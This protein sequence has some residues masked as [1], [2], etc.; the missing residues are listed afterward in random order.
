V[1][2]LYLCGAGNSEGVR[3]AHTINRAED[4]WD[5][6]LLLD[7]DETKRGES[8][9]GVEIVGSLDL[10][11]DPGEGVV[12]IANLVARTTQ[13]RAAVRE[14]LLAFD[15][16]FATLISPNVDVEGVEYGQDLIV[17][18]N[19]TLGPEVT[20][21]E[22]TVVFMGGVLGHECRVGNCCVIA[23]NAV[24]NARVE[25]ADRVYVGTNATILPETK[26]GEGSTVGAGSVVLED[27]PPGVTVMG[28]PAEIIAYRDAQDI[29]TESFA[30][31]HPLSQSVAPLE[32]RIEIE[33]QL[34]QIWKEALALQEIDR[35]ENF[36][37]IGGDSLRA[38]KVRN[39]VEQTTGT[40][41]HL[42]DLFRFPTVRSL[43]E[44]IAALQYG[45]NGSTSHR[46]SRATIRRRARHLR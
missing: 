26:V 21:G 39:A 18:Q 5:R 34:T 37:Q 28:V 19:A 32:T 23:S 45:G 3:L 43:A 16:P 14:R 1:R 42:T 38:C 17:Y 12:E 44:H 31:F 46:S 35:E 36:F 29:P 11:R 30:E 15:L 40:D 27:V 4:R 8:R 22:G 33:E 24:L 7:D 25:L 6:I 9:I 10:L 13:G 41:L 2:T 20:I